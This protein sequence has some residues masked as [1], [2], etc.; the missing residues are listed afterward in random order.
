MSV[1]ENIAIIRRFEDEVW[2]RRNLAVVD[3]LFSP[4]HAFHA[5]GSPLLDREGHKHMIMHFQSAFP[6]GQNDTDEIVAEGDRVAHRWT[7]RGTHRGEFQGIPPTHK[8]V[9]LTGISIWRFEAG[10]VVESWHQ[11]DALGLLQQLGVLPP[12]GAK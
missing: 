8:Q 7:Y 3:Q 12:S 10:K 9:V 2:N 5:P 6:D 4:S 11:L 1:K